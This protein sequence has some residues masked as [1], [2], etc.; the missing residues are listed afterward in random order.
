[1]S[2]PSP[3]TPSGW[4]AAELATLAELAETFV[5]GGSVRRSNLAAEALSRAADPAQVRQLKLVLGALES[6]VANLLLTGRRTPFRDRT[7]AER[8]RVLLSWANSRLAL[9]R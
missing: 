1:M 4:S 9:R 6:P 2:S 8:E 3:T 7:P 5:R